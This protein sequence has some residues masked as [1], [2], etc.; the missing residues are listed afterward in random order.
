MAH[1]NSVPEHQEPCLVDSLYETTL[2]NDEFEAIIESSFDGNGIISGDGSR[3][4][5]NILITG[6]SGVGKEIIAKVV[7]KG[8]LRSNGPF[9]QINCGAIPDNLTGGYGPIQPGEKLEA[10]LL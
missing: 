1:K 9:M 8:S 10:I 4:N 3:V 6:E 5:S 7:H 2:T